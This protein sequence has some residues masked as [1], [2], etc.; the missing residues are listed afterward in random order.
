V[1][2]T[3]A[4]RL[5]RLLVRAFT[6]VVVLLAVCVS[7][8]VRPLLRALR[9]F[10]PISVW[11]GAP[12]INMAINAR[13]ERSLGVCTRSIVTNT[14]FTTAEFDIVLRS[15]SSSRW[16]GQI[17]PFVGFVWICLT[18]NRIHSYCDSGILPSSR[19]MTFNRLEM[20]AYRCLRIPVLVWTYG[21]DVRTRVA[22]Q[23]LGEPNCCTDCTDVGRACVCDDALWRENLAYLRRHARAIFAMGD[24]TEYTPG[25]RNDLFFWPVDLARDGGR[26]YAPAYPD[27]NDDRPLRVVHAPN[28]RQFKGTKYL[29]SAIAT[30]RA[31]RVPIELLLVE[32]VPNN[33]ALAIY[34]T[35]DIVFDQC[36]IGFHG[37]FAIE[38]MAL[39]KPVMCFIRKP[40]QY[41]LHP[42]ECPIL[43]VH[44]DD[45]L[46]SLRR[47]ATTSRASLPGIGRQSRVYVERHYS[48]DAF[49]SRLRRCY[50]DLKVAL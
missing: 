12:I 49:A 23:A 45:V 27:V 3:V 20:F 29:E 2:S 43:N 8:L 32:R 21:A 13:A 18:A 17:A 6:I 22:T 34:R 47:Y 50:A 37:Y 33:Q 11:T 26:R 5:R 10:R 44:R 31:D 46:E 39:G 30:L 9:G 19:R 35:A 7:F 14:Y 28:H 1:K 48:M 36:L 42:E 15:Y 24:M 4:S 16:W 40:E 25:S 41:L 38:A